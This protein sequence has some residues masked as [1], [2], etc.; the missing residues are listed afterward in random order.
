M[1][2]RSTIFGCSAIVKYITLLCEYAHTYIHVYDMTYI[3]SHVYSNFKYGSGV[4]KKEVA[5]E[6]A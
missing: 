2:G 1:P 6:F 5:Q 4:T 3:T